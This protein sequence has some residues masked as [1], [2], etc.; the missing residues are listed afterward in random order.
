MITVVGAAG[1]IGGALTARLAQTG[2]A[3]K[4]IGRDTAALF[5]QPLGTV[6]Y[7]AGVTTDFARR[8]H[9]TVEAHAAQLCDIFQNSDFDRFIYL[10]ST[11]VYMGGGG[12]GED[13]DIS[14]QPGN[15]DH[16]YNLSKLLG[17]NLC[18]YCPRPAVV[19]RL[20]NV[21]GFDGSATNFLP[22]IIRQALT[23]GEIVF[24]TALESAKDYISLPSAMDLLIAIAERGKSPT[25]NLASGRNVSHGEIAKAIARVTGCAIRV[26]DGAQ[27]VIF[28]AIDVA[29]LRAEFG[30]PGASL[31]D[32]IPQLVAAY[33]AL[34]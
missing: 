3:H 14:V 7:C 31:L 29:R 30:E 12:T 28:P 32:D 4:A 23:K 24:E 22:I 9:D 5:G 2:V 16:L 34:A 11:R 27:T 10:S 8:P 15:P 17:E 21:Y 1:Y 19:V 20:S 33:R 13:A 26:Q 6:I 25:Y 18:R